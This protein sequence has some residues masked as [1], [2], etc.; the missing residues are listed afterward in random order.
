M[1]QTQTVSTA[2]QQHEVAAESDIGVQDDV[3]REQASVPLEQSQQV[4]EQADASS[5]VEPTPLHGH[6]PQQ[7]SHHQE[8]Q[9][10]VAELQD[11]GDAGRHGSDAVCSRCSDQQQPIAAAA[12]AD[13]VAIM[14]PAS[15]AAEGKRLKQHLSSTAADTFSSP[16]QLIECRICL[17]TDNRQDLLQPC[18][19]TGTVQYAH[20]EC[21]KAWVSE[22]GSL[23]CELCGKQYKDSIKQQLEPLVDAWRSQ[24]QQR[25]PR[26][27]SGDAVLAINIVPEEDVEQGRPQVSWTR[28]WVHL[29]LLVMLLVGV[30][31]LALFVNIGSPDNFWLMFLWRAITIILPLFLIVR[32]VAALYAWRRHYMAARAR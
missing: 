27:A 31:Y 3:G 7:Q 13:H 26:V 16:E 24:H 28:F 10:Q 29:G 23:E 6:L 32:C 1:H 30:L 12:T 19:C 4:Q 11:T 9:Q 21:L 17:A 2:C 5:R 20:M 14:L 15:T 22:R 18:S 25:R 8:T